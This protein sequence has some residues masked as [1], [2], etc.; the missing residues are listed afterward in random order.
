MSKVKDIA[1]FEYLKIVKK[2]SFW[3]STLFFPIFM[4]LIMF[5]SGWSSYQSS[6][7]ME[8]GLSL[9][10]VY[11]VDNQDII[12]S[13]K[14]VPPLFKAES[15][16]AVKDELINDS[17]I[18]LVVLP[19]DFLST[20]KYEVLYKDD[21]DLM[22]AANVPALMSGVI[23]SGAIESIENERSKVLLSGEIT[24]ETY[25]LDAEGNESKQG[26]DKFIVPILSMLVFFMA[27]FISSTYLLQSVSNEK[28]NRMIET[29]LSI[30]DK[31]SLMIGKMVGLMAVVLT[32]LL[33]WLIFA[34]VLTFVATKFLDMSLPINLN[35]I[36]LRTLPF[37]ILMIILGFIFFGA[38]MVGVGAIG[39]GAEDSRNLSTIFVMLSVA[40]LYVIQPLIMEP[41]SLI[42]RIF[43]YF[44]FS[45]YMVAVLRNSLGTLPPREL[46]LTIVFGIV[47][48]VIAIAISYKLFEIGCLMYNRRPTIKE[49]MIF[50][51]QGKQRD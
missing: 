13:D 9:E 40:P 21:G 31:K 48:V 10:K 18:V 47:Y 36:D 5:I 49:I 11:V 15:K 2:G 6:K 51:F 12:P 39:T 27:V 42:S 50:L 34:V 23:K 1:K 43:T 8:K 19:E 7:N 26:F 30:V 32:Q 45:S 35:N 44:P 14:I 25:T 22:R 17:K 33:I 29:M 16:E 3:A 28:E 38:V 24:S 41:E 20:L 37:T 4:A 46:V